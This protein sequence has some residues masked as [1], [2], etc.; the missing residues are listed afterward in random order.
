MPQSL[1]ALW[2]S[3]V[4]LGVVFFALGYLVGFM[5]HTYCHGH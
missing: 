2:A 5:L 4:V 3:L 1:L